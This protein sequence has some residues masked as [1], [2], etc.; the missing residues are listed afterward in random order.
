MSQQ[1]DFGR[2][3]RKHSYGDQDPIENYTSEALAIAIEHDDGS[4]RVALKS[5]RWPRS[6][7]FDPD[8]VVQIRPKP[9]H[10]LPA[11]DLAPDGE[12]RKVRYGYVDLMLTLTR[13]NGGCCT[14]WV[15]VKIDTGEHG[16]PLDVYADH[17]GSDPGRPCLF[18]LSKWEV[19]PAER[20]PKGVD[21]GWLSWK[22]L[23]AAI[24]QTPGSDSR[25]ADLLSF[26]EEEGIA[27]RSLPQ[28]RVDTEAHIRVVG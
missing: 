12:P 26:F 28:D 20:H 11:A 27:W 23:A 9:Q 24:E 8:D 1:S 19:R 17:A 14:A 16:N 13:A 25:W 5:I 6:T 7:P 15:E 18:T 3:F 10:F 2:L 22:D 4:M 21:I